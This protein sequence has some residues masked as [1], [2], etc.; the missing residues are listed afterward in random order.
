MC[1]LVLGVY[2]VKLD[3]YRH[4]GSLDPALGGGDSPGTLPRKQTLCTSASDS[5]LPT[6]LLSLGMFKGLPRPETCRG[7][8]GVR[9]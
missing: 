9:S 6:L 1:V 3:P 8:A 5:A 2:N 4:S 7:R